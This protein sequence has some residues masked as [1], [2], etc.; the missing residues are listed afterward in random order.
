MGLA[1]TPSDH[2]RQNML[3]AK[4]PRA[5]MCASIDQHSFTQK[6]DRTLNDRLA[7][8]PRTRCGRPVANLLTVLALQCPYSY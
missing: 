6:E 1:A 4:P 7:Q 8:M 3:G 2:P 5:R